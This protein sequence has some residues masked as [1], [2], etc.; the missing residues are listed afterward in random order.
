MNAPIRDG[1]RL[2]LDTLEARN[3]GAAPRQPAVPGDE[4]LRQWFRHA[5]FDQCRMPGSRDGGLVMGVPIWGAPY[6]RRFARYGL[7]SLLAPK[8]R[9]ALADGNARLILFSDRQ[10]LN[11][12]YEMTEQLKLARLGLV[13]QLIE[14]PDQIMQ[15]MTTFQQAKYLV[16]GTVQNLMPQIAKRH[17]MAFHFWMPD[18]IYDPEYFPKLSALGE[19]HH[20]I[21][22][23]CTS[24]LECADSVKEIDRYRQ[25]PMLA[26]P[27]PELTR[28]GWKY[29]HP[30]TRGAILADA[31]NKMPRMHLVAWPTKDRLRMH[32]P[33]QNPAWLSPLACQMA[34]MVAP[35]SLDAEVPL[36]M[37]GPFYVPKPEDG[38]ACVEVSDGSK[39]GVPQDWSFDQFAYNF[40]MNSNGEDA[41]MRFFEATT[42]I[43]IGEKT[44]PWWI[45]ANRERK[46][47]GEPLL[48]R[49][50][51]AVAGQQLKDIVAKL[52]ELQGIS[53]TRFQ[54]QAA[55]K[56]R[57]GL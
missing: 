2:I 47:A 56:M 10:G 29:L 35:I 26:I 13:P 20:A 32:C 46:K 25:G 51:D 48:T 5:L 39:P 37:P 43:D 30:Q 14:I 1:A 8:N 52:W 54:R 38:L 28:L 15:F 19:Q 7:A 3:H 12:L 4:L 18:H 53:G 11:V 34:P 49:Y 45:A 40:W 42:E 57:I 36:L 55:R 21:A 16:L 9:E 24:M 44:P 22:Q 23:L 27:G 6:I 41:A 33:H 31:P 50:S 17:G